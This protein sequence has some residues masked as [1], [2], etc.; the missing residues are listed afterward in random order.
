MGRP[1]HSLRLR[2]GDAALNDHWSVFVNVWSDIN[3]NADSGLGGD[4]QEIDLNTG[5]SYTIE[6]FSISLSHGFWNYASDQEKVVD[7]TV[8]SM[9]PICS[10]R[11]S[12]SIPR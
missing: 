4:V 2:D 6:K 12:P 1:G 3:D 7:L 8:A 11:A 10:P 9:T 5:V